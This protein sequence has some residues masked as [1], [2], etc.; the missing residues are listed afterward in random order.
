MLNKCF[1]KAEDDLVQRNVDEEPRLQSC[2]SQIHPANLNNNDVEE[3]ARILERV[4]LI[5]DTNIDL[6][7]IDV[8]PLENFSES[9]DSDFGVECKRRYLEGQ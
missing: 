6:Q 7:D 1:R 2:Q 4:T 3:C 8:A 9:N 5:K